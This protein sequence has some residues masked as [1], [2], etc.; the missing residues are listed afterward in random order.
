M[1]NYTPDEIR[2]AILNHVQPL[3]RGAFDRTSKLSAQLKELIGFGTGDRVQHAMPYGLVSKPYSGILA[4]FLNLLGK[5]QAPVIVS[6]LDRDRPDPAAEG[7]VILYCLSADR[8]LT[9]VRATL[10]PD[11]KFVLYAQTKIQIGSKDSDQPLV[12]GTELKDLL[13]TVLAKLSQLSDE[14]A[15]HQHMGNLGY[16]T[17]PPVTAATFSTLKETFD[18][19]KASPVDDKVILSDKSFTEK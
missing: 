8:T 2:Q 1:R 14:V 18:Q 6:H 3:Y 16:N 7:E 13:S 12:L 4:Y 17:P 11:G 10:S 15:K 5:S 9:P 19:L